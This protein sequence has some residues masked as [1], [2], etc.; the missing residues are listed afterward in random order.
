M[1]NALLLNATAGYFARNET[2]K[3]NGER[4]NFADNYFVFDDIL[5]TGHGQC[6]VRPGFVIVMRARAISYDR[7]SVTGCARMAPTMAHA[8]PTQSLVLCQWCLWALLLLLLSL[9]GF[10]PFRLA[11]SLEQQH[12]KTKTR[13]NAV[14]HF[15]FILF[16]AKLTHSFVCC[17]MCAYVAVLSRT[18]T[19]VARCIIINSGVA[20]V[21]KCVVCC[22]CCSLV[23]WRLLIDSKNC[24]FACQR[25]LEKNLTTS[26]SI[27]IN[28][29][30]QWN[31]NIEKRIWTKW[32]THAETIWSNR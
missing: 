11:R 26:L 17:C 2:R 21:S 4:N 14:F 23:L 24:L 29:L 1:I 16:C 20:V 31:S 12:N 5:L 32:V 27:K 30:A 19:Q 6:A 3:K 10:L 22:C 9:S 13:K 18:W 25:Q 8:K 15:F 28:G 7:L